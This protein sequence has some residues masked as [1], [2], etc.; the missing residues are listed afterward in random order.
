MPEGWTPKDSHKAKARDLGL[1]LS[2]EAEAFADFHVARGNRFADWDR[3]FHTWLRNATKYG[4]AVKTD[5]QESGE[6]IEVPEDSGP[7]MSLAEALEFC[8]PEHRAPIQEFLG[9]IR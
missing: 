3:A 2:A 6:Y 7:I 8:P 5:A 9:G 1:N 4:P